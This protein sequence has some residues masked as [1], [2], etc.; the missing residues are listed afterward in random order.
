MSTRDSEAGGTVE[1]TV[2]LPDPLATEARAAGLLTPEA[3]AR[4]LREEIRRRSVNEL[5]EAMDRM[6]A[7][8]G[9]PM[10][11]DEIQAEVDAVRAAHRQPRSCG[12]SLTPTLSSRG[13][14]GR[15]S[16]PAS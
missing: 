3:V 4:M 9:E 8:P 10:T 16:R 15:A 14:F 7:V 12:S 6:A 2:N 13:C 11:E 5:F 1:F